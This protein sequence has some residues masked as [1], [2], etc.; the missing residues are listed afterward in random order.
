MRVLLICPSWGRACGIAS[1]TEQLRLGLSVLGVE[2]D[3]APSSALIQRYLNEKRYDGVLLQHEYGLYYFNLVTVLTLVD[4]TDL[5]FVIT[6]HN[7]DHRGWMGAQH[8]FLFKTR[9]KFVVHSG[10]ARDNLLQ[11]R[12]SPDPARLSV[13]AMGSPDYRDTLGPTA[14][15]R[16]EMGLPRNGFVVGFFGFA[17]GHKGIA[18]LV[19][20]LALLPD[21]KGY[22]GATVHPVNP[23]AVGAIY[24]ECGLSRQASGRSEHG[25]VLLMHEKIP[26]ERFGR[27]Q[28][29]VDMIIFP[30]TVHGTSISTSMMAHQSLASGRPVVTTDVPYFSDLGDEV[31]KIPDNQPATIAGAIRTLRDDP[32]LRAILTAKAMAYA[33]EHRW[34][35]VAQAYLDLL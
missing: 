5:P 18:N 35:R 1:Y 11:A 10:L 13:I 6:M 20:A 30:Y 16:R 28:N 2:S 15:V 9:A 21:V 23:A 31:L 4:R 24:G 25:N 32:G 27:Y 19:K 26:G 17:A 7:T 8:L 33:A 14:E 22:I 12:P 29:A 34:P 3:V